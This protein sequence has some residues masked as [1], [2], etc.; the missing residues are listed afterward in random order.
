MVNSGDIDAYADLLSDNA[1]WIPPGQ[2]PIVGRAAFREW[3]APFF[4]EFSYEF[5]IRDKR[6]KVSGDWA[7]E[8]ARFISGMTPRNGGK[9]MKHTGSFTAIWK[10]ENEN[11]WLIERYI[12]DTDIQGR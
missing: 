6:I 7:L 5:D 4:A 2:Q 12:D 11:I 3:L 9:T 8:R 1:V 10:R